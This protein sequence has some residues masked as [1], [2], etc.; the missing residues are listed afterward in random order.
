MAL[1]RRGQRLS[2]FIRNALPMRLNPP[3]V[4][5]VDDDDDDRFLIGRVFQKHHPDCLLFM[6]ADGLELLEYLT[7]QR[8]E[9]PSLVLLDL[10]MPVMSGFET[11]QRLQQNDRLRAIPAVVLSTSADETDRARSHRLGAKAFFTKPTRYT[12]LVQLIDRIL[13]GEQ[14][15]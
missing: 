14:V 6:F 3:I 12:D 9:E 13:V 7:E 10:N 4:Y 15:F 11:L 5:V 2:S 8:G 1:V